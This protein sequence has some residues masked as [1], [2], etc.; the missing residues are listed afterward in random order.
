[1]VSLVDRETIGGVDGAHST[2]CGSEMEH[3]MC[4]A[5]RALTNGNIAKISDDLFV[6]YRC[7]EGG[8][9]DN[10]N[11]PNVIASAIKVVS[12]MRTLIMVRQN[13]IVRG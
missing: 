13:E 1:V 3:G 4:A 6:A 2:H 9:V 10:I 8:M 12:K 11:D 5:H 7:T